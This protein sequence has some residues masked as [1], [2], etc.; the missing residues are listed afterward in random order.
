LKWKA[1]GTG[2]N[3]LGKSLKKKKALRELAINNFLDIPNKVPDDCDYVIFSGDVFDKENTDIQCYDAYAKVLTQLCKMPNIKKI[4]IIP[5][6]HDE[7]NDY[8]NTASVNLIGG[9]ESDKLVICD[10]GHKFYYDKDNDVLFTLLPYSKDLFLTNEVGGLKLVDKINEIIA[11][12]FNKPEYENSYKV[13]ISHF[14][15]TEW[16]PFGSETIS[17]E[18]LTAGNHFDLIIL[19]DLH[20][21]TYEDLSQPTKII[22][23]GSTCHTTITD[24]Y[25][26]ENVAK[27]ITINDKAIESIDQIKFNKP[28]IVIVDESNIE[29]LQD[30][31]DED[32]IVIT[33][34]LEIHTSLKDRVMFSMYKPKVKLSDKLM[35]DLGEGEDVEA[36][37][38]D[39]IAKKK[40]DEDT[41]INDDTKKFLKFLVD[42]DTDSYGPKEIAE[43]VANNI[44]E[45]LV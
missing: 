17:K 14:A 29:S 21:E 26:H 24:L 9:L 12:L 34:S 19:G 6:N 8:Y 5:G 23:T 45:G 7:F 4:L 10:K 2:D 43:D 15:I 16:M 20:N 40:I 35:D 1:F 44:M 28:N 22:Y 32:T 13:L 41:T 25:N 18:E 3:H 38:I 37:D 30:Q 31:L 11:E 39:I 33:S 42:I 27:Y 36:L